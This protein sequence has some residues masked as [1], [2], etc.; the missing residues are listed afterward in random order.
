M[1]IGNGTFTLDQDKVLLDA[2]NVTRCALPGP[3]ICSPYQPPPPAIQAIT[4]HA[5]GTSGG[6]KV[7]VMENHLQRVRDAL[8]RTSLAKPK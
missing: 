1:I 4:Y 3:L 2:N 7:S 5:I 6:G 8:N